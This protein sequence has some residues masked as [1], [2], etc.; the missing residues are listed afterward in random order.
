MLNNK[1]QV[2]I[3]ERFADVNKTL[4]SY[5]YPTTK[6]IRQ[7]TPDQQRV[8]IP[9]S[10]N[11]DVAAPVLNNYVLNTDALTDKKVFYG[12]IRK[13]TK[14][15]AKEN[16][17]SGTVDI[18]MF[19]L[20]QLQT[21]PYI[22]FSLYKINNVLHW[23]TYNMTGKQISNVVAHMKKQYRGLDVEITYEGQFKYN[24]KDQIWLRYTDNNETIQLGRYKDKFMWCL[25]SEIVNFKKT[26]TFEISYDVT[27]FFLKNNDFIY[28]KDDLGEIYEIPMVGY[29]GNYYKR[30]AFAAVIGVLRADESNRANSLGPYYYFGSYARAMRFAFWSENHEPYKIADEWLTVGEDGLYR[31]GGLV[32]MALFLGNLTVLLNRSTDKEDKSKAVAVKKKTSKFMKAIAKTRDIEGTW[33]E[34][35]QSAIRGALTITVGPKPSYFQP[36][37]VLYKYDQQYPLEYYYVNTSQ[38]FNQDDVLTD[39]IVE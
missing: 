27:R 8:D 16:D 20:N 4:L 38:N 18:C 34:N 22:L 32:R 26:L 1:T 9:L 29:Y 25:C 24:G 30:I 15:R 35:Y 36:S 39:A 7:H 23:P 17:I 14:K 21:K 13:L 19:Q 28:L 37:I 11:D 12:G 31:K 5:S 2:K 10:Q 3:R 33:T 6:D